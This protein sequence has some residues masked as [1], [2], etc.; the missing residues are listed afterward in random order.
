MQSFVLVVV[1]VNIIIIIIIII[2]VIVIVTGLLTLPSTLFSNPIHDTH[3]A[4]HLGFV[5][6]IRDGVLGLNSYWVH[7]QGG[8]FKA[9]IF[10]VF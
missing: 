1:V 5:C 2:I 4:S 9:C 7:V 8:F 10:W 6:G 3:I